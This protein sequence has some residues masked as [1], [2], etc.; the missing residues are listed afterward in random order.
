M[1]VKMGW[2]NVGHEADM[3]YATR[4]R[5]RE[6]GASLPIRVGGVAGLTE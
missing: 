2:T 1:P 4:F 6:S 5:T 3:R